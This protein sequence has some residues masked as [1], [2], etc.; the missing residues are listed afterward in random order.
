MLLI[1]TDAQRQMVV[2]Q[3]LVGR[4]IRMSGLRSRDADLLGLEN[5]VL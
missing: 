1:H 2:G 3:H 5:D 4:F